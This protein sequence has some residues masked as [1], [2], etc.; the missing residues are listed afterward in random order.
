[1]TNNCPDCEGLP[2]EVVVITGAIVIA[3]ILLVYIRHYYNGG[4]E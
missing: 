4:E 2:L 1:M 3:L